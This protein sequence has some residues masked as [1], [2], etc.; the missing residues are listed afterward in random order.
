MCVKLTSKLLWWHLKLTQ[1]CIQ[2]NTNGSQNVNV[3]VT[4]DSDF[5]SLYLGADK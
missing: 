2:L 3:N 4:N 1:V 5:I